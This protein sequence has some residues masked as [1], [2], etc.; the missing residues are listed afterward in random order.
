MNKLLVFLSAIFLLLCTS[1]SKKVSIAEGNLTEVSESSVTI[2]GIPYQV[3]NGTTDCFSG[4]KIVADGKNAYIY[5]I[6]GKL[7]VSRFDPL[8][9]NDFVSSHWGWKLIVTLQFVLLAFAFVTANFVK[10]YKKKLEANKK[11]SSYEE[12]YYKEKR[13]IFIGV[14]VL[15][16]LPFLFFVLGKI[17]PD[18]FTCC[19]HKAI[20]QFIDYGTLTQQDG[21]TKTINGVDRV[22]A[23]R[24]TNNKTPELFKVGSNYACV[25]SD[26]IVYFYRTDDVIAL[27][28]VIAYVNSHDQVFF[29]E[30]ATVVF[31]LSAIGL[32][33]W[34]FPSLFEVFMGTTKKR[35][36]HGEIEENERYGHGTMKTV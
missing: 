13:V 32:L 20:V 33:L 28:K 4:E 36:M 6:N 15:S 12:D 9:L 2:D 10:S 17:F 34:V 27:K 29:S 23:Q 18:N 30:I 1:C 16:F 3:E 7:A 31:G 5:K 24:Y 19:Q 35:E 25:S 26:G 8:Y 22:I 21:T 11:I 14:A